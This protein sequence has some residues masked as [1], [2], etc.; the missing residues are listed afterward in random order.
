MKQERLDEIKKELEKL[1][2]LERVLVSFKI[3][4]LVSIK[5]HQ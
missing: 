2:D 5:A 4:S 1:I 3:H